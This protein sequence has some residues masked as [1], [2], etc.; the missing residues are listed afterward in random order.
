[1]QEKLRALLAALPCHS[2]IMGWNT[3][4]GLNRRLLELIHSFSLPCFLWL[5][6]LAEAQG[7]K[8]CRHLT[9]CSGVQSKRLMHFEE[10]SFQFYC[11][12][13]PFSAGHL[14]EIYEQY[15]ACLPFDGVFLDKIRF[16]SFANGYED[17]FGCFCP[18][19][20]ADFIKNG[21]D[22]QA[23]RERIARHDR[24]LTEGEY[25]GGLYRFADPEVDR[26]YRIRSAQI[27][28]YVGGLVRYFKGRGLK[29]GLDIYA[30][31]FAY[32]VGQDIGRLTQEADFI[33]PMLYRFTTAPAGIRYEYDAYMRWFDGDNSF[34]AY[35]KGD[36]SSVESISRQ[37]PLLDAAGCAVYPGI[38]VNVIEGMSGVTEERLRENLELFSGLGY[39]T[40]ACCWNCLKTG[41]SFTDILKQK[42]A[43]K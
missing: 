8:E 9:N 29:V 7:V 37:K 17:G 36:P 42:A 31:F 19:C 10:E 13:D 16:P 43:K 25:R 39:Q 32:H 34:S 26:F 23:I 6:A 5:P 20:T 40:L 15:F 14:Q 35:W 33:K 41:D 30:P 11:P 18:D 21:L 2:V 1:M 24:S 28:R 4:A 38:E 27:T 22:V 12:S 3:D